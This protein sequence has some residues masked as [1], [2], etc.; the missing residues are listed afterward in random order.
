LKLP[1]LDYY[2]AAICLEFLVGYLLALCLSWLRRHPCSEWGSLLFLLV[3]LG[4]FV[5]A[6]MG[7]DFPPDGRD[8]ALIPRM[9]I[10][11]ADGSSWPRF[12]TW[13]MPAAVL[14]LGFLGIESHVPRAAIKFGQITYSMY[15]LQHFFLPLSGKLAGQGL[16]LGWSILSVMVML[17]LAS[18]ISFR[19]FENPVNSWWR[20]KV[21]A[22]R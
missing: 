6:G 12:F 17:L 4:L 18:Y 15:L 10:Y 2:A 13:G 7:K 5:L 3:G 22:Q 1:A 21:S 11:H 8:L 20:Q 9:V 16:P 14:T 19:S